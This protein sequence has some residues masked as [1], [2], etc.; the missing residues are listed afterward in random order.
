MI[1]VI[2][3]MKSRLGPA[4]AILPYCQTPPVQPTCKSPLYFQQLA[5]CLFCKSFPLTFMRIARGWGVETN[6]RRRSG[7]ESVA[8]VEMFPF[9][10]DRNEK[11]SRNGTRWKDPKPAH[12]IRRAGRYTPSS[13]ASSTANRGRLRAPSCPASAG[14]PSATAPPRAGTTGRCFP[15]GRS[16]C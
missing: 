13:G 7:A 16:R 5:H 4:E 2:F 3:H 9:L 8:R 6:I 15:T 11:Q 10:R 12:G 14:R 1:M